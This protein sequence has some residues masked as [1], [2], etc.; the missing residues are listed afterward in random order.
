MAL[1]ALFFA[2]ALHAQTAPNTERAFRDSVVQ[3]QL[4]LQNF[5]ADE[6]VRAVWDGTLLRLPNT[7]TM[8]FAA[9]VP[10]SVEVSATHVRLHGTLQLVKRDSGSLRRLLLDAT[11]MPTTVYVD[12]HGATA[13]AT[14]QQMRDLLF[15]KDINDA[16]HHLPQT[17]LSYI[18]PPN[19][20]I[21]GPPPAKP[22]CDCGDT[23]AAC[24]GLTQEPASAGWKGPVLVGSMDEVA[25][26]TASEQTLKFALQ[27]ESTGMVSGVWILRYAEAGAART[28]SRSM[29]ADLFKPAT[30]HDQPTATTFEVTTQVQSN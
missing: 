13:S 26:G 23:A 3:K 17:A 22:A 29:G 2:A 15:F 28:F 12:L 8:A 20:E 30:C 4:Y 25:I 24:K 21:K 10:S 16:L 9:F 19:V 7:K 14:L 27:V 6:E 11:R 18:P 5:S 1:A